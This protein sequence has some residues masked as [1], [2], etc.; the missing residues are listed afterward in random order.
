MKY[1]KVFVCSN[2]GTEFVK[3]YIMD[4]CH[5]VQDSEYL[6]KY[7]LQVLETHEC[8]DWDIGMMVF[9]CFRKVE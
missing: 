3:E 4:D 7:G 8:E 2:C 9:K 1:K 5:M 6:R